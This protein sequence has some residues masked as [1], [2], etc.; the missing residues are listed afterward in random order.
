MF[1]NLFEISGALNIK[2]CLR[3]SEIDAL[4]IKECLRISE[5]DALNIKEC[6]RIC[7]RFSVLLILR[8]V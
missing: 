3:I 8:N 1:E 2:E 6:L 4:N 5:I 7:L